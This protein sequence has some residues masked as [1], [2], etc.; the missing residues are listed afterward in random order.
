MNYEEELKAYVLSRRSASIPYKALHTYT[1]TEI[2]NMLRYIKD[3]YKALE[4]LLGHGRIWKM[5]AI[6]AVYTLN[7]ETIRNDNYFAIL[8]KRL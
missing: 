3:N 8:D 5:R 4:L 1:K 2:S 7:L 6:L